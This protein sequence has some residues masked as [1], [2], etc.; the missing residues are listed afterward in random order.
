MSFVNTPAPAV[1]ASH[2]RPAVGPIRG[3]SVAPWI[4]SRATKSRCAPTA[5]GSG[6]TNAGR[7][8]DAAGPRTAM[9]GR[10]NGAAPQ[11]GVP[12]CL[13]H[14]L[15]CRLTRYIAGQL[16]PGRASKCS[17]RPWPVNAR[18]GV[19]N[20]SR[21]P[22]PAQA[23]LLRRLPGHPTTPRWIAA[24]ATVPSGRAQAMHAPQQISGKTIR[25]DNPE[26]Q[27][28]QCPHSVVR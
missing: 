24:P 8:V 3:F 25:Q 9:G 21:A 23:G 13:G 1:Q 16:L 22:S 27:D 5:H 26:R 19:G 12:R 11:Q 17:A 14:A 28:G 15:G 2:D 18:R 4:C 6:Q 10:A 20:A 7:G